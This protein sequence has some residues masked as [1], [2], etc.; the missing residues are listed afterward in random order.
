MQMAEILASAFLNRNEVKS[1]NLY[2]IVTNSF[3]NLEKQ[4][5]THFY[6]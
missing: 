4:E 6:K 1:K 5:A 3:I 2:F